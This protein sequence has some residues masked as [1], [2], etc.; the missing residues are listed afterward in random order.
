MKKKIEKPWCVYG[1]MWPTGFG[2]IIEEQ[3]RCVFIRYYE[4]Q[5]Y[6]NQCWDKKPCYV[7]RFETLEEA[8]KYYQEYCGYWLSDWKLKEKM[9]EA[10]P[11]YFKQKKK[12]VK[13]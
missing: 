2:K 6:E 9:I 8:A 12:R 4:D 1:S 11:S 7:K 10:F 13:K 3:D 5:L